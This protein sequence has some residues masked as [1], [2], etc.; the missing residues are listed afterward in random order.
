MSDGD[1][2]EQLRQSVQ[3]QLALI[4]SAARAAKARIGQ[5]VANA[6]TVATPPPAPTASA[7]PPQ[8]PEYTGLP[9]TRSG[10]AVDFFADEPVHDRP[11]EPEDPAFAA[12]VEGGG[13]GLPEGSIEFDN[14]AQE[15]MDDDGIPV[16][17]EPP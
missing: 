14:Y 12:A 2:A 15:G 10:A 11:L 6:T 17:E 5:G 3:D 13:E 9:P 4:Q 7:V 1:F 16:W 8:V